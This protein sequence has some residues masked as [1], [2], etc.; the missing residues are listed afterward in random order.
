MA[1]KRV[2]K[3][4]LTDKSI[5]E[6]LY[7]IQKKH[8]KACVRKMDDMSTERVDVISTG[9][10]WVDEAL[11]IGGFPRGRIVEIYGPEGGGKAQP[12]DSKVLTPRGW[13][14][15]RDLFPGSIVF[16]SSGKPSVVLGVFPQGEKEI[17]KV[18]FSDGSSTEC[19]RDHLWA[20][21]TWDDKE[22]DL[23]RVLPLTELMIDFK[24]TDRFKYYIPM[25]SPINF[26]KKELPLDPY[27]LGLLLG[28]GCFRNATIRMS[29]TDAE[30]VDA[31]V[32]YAM[33]TNQKVTQVSKYDYSIS[34]KTR[35]H[36]KAPL[37]NIL[38]EL[39]LH[40]HTSPVKFI[41]DCYLYSSVEDRLAVLQGLL[42]TDG[43]IC[44]AHQSLEY[45]TTSP[46]LKD[47]V[48][49]I[50]RSLGG[51]VNVAT[52]K[53]HYIKAGAC[54]SG[55]R[56]YRIIIML[57][58]NLMPF[59]L[60]RKKNVLLNN[61]STAKCDY[62]NRWITDIIPVGKKEASCILID[63]PDHLYI[64]DDFIVTHNT[65]LALHCIAEAQRAGGQA[66]FIDAEHALDMNL[67]MKIGVDPAKLVIS[68]PDSGEQALE[69]FEMAVSSG[70][71]DV[72]V[73]D[74]VSALTPQSEIDGNM[75]DAQMGAQARLMGQGMRKISTP[76]ART[77]TL[78]IFINQVRHKIGVMFGNPETT[79]GGNAL[80]FYAS[81]RVDIRRIGSLKL[82]EKIVG[83]RVQVKIVKNKLAP[84]FKVIQTDLIFGSGFSKEAELLAM[85]EEKDIVEL[86]GTKYYYKGDL[87]GKGKV[88]AITV[89]KENRDTYE[90]IIADIKI[91]RATSED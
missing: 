26:P 72:A 28:D 91:E 5:D 19:C 61:R 85:A 4:D 76:V 78:A 41:P 80:K 14:T 53:T 65:T 23:W 37:R 86:R 17:F 39:N 70:K 18:V 88:G 6:I 74:S 82:K 46:W 29:T 7:E 2:P 57:P 55:K 63:D 83:N 10:F 21:Q 16:S 30:I 27:I 50:V 59:R 8:G 73:I 36:E 67:A 90:S 22:N 35:S 13:K 75:G 34:K 79:S 12:L 68:Q 47:G 24:L 3:A 66:I 58:H 56:A 20:V 52:K 62:L 15:I 38:E 45:I 69:I 64:T 25:V 11:G 42:D 77:G 33:S 60:S 43:H 49:H 54:V 87:L 40:N 44:K 32:D 51:K 1:K 81:V 48:T 89:L 84:P 71:F 31:I 9:S